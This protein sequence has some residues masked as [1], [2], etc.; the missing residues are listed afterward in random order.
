[1]W[2][3]DSLEKTMMFGKIEGKR[4]RG[5]QRMRWLDAIIDLMDMSLNKLWELVMDREAWYAVAH[6]VTNSW[7]WLSD[8]TELRRQCLLTERSAGEG[9]GERKAP[10]STDLRQHSQT[11]AVRSYQKLV[12]CP[13]TLRHK[14]LCSFWGAMTTEKH[15]KIRS[16]GTDEKLCISFASILWKHFL[17]FECKFF[18][19]KYVFKLVC[20]EYNSVHM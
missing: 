1:M 13:H 8:W 6:G 14:S 16:C 7:T 11:T 12:C 17:Y 3:A 20:S 4:R 10:V 15:L 18:Q 9:Q 2:R 19:R 5:Q